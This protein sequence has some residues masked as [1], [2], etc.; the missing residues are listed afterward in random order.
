MSVSS[1][2]LYSK[3]SAADIKKRNIESS[4][5][6]VEDQNILFRLGLTVETVSNS[7]SSRL[8]DDTK[9]I[10]TR[11]GTGVFGGKT[12]GVIEVS[13]YTRNRNCC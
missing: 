9:N 3:H 1:S 10:E 2:C 6:Q 4:P 11:N 12:L 13:R 8:V 5:S 7:S